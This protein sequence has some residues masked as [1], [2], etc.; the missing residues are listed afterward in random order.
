MWYEKQTKT[1]KLFLVMFHS[2]HQA[3]REVAKTHSSKM[4]KYFDFYR[5]P[6]VTDRQAPSYSEDP[7]EVEGMRTVEY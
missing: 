4:Q 3:P 5:L 2:S 6:N 1:P 7:C